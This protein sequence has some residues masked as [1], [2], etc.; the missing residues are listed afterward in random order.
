MTIYRYMTKSEG[1]LCFVLGCVK[2]INF[3]ECQAMPDLLTEVGNETDYMVLFQAWYQHRHTQFDKIVQ[4]NFHKI[5][6]Q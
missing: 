4:N 2:N 1:K 6:F 3:V 5:M